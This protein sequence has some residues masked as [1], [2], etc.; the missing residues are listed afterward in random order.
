[1]RLVLTGGVVFLFE[2]W[3]KS[4]KE[5]VDA[6]KAK[7]TRLKQNVDLAI[8]VDIKEEQL[9]AVREQTLNRIKPPEKSSFD[10]ENCCMPDTRTQIVETLVS[11]ALSKD[12]SPRLFLLSGLAGSGKSAVATSVA[13]SLYQHCSLSGSFFFK[14]DIERL[15]IPANLLHAVAYSIALQYKP[16]M[17]VLIDALKS[18]PAIEDAALSIQFDALLRKPLAEVSNLSSTSAVGPLSKQP[19]VTF[20]IDALDECDKPPAIS[21][22]LAELISL[23]PW[24]KVIVTSRPMYECEAEL[25][26]S[27]YMTR[28]NLFAVD[29]SED[30]LKFTQSQFA[31]GRLLHRLQS[32]VTEEEIRAL[33]DKSHGLF[34]WIKT[35]LSYIASLAYDGAKLKEMRSILSSSRAASPENGVDELYL[36]VLRKV[37]GESPGHQDAVK[38][39]V[40]TIYVTSRNR[41][42]PCKGLHAFIPTSDPDILISPGDIEE[43][44]S[45]LAA[46]I[47]VDPVT[48]A[49]RVCHPSFL[50]FISV[51]A[52]SQEFWTDPEM[53]DTMMARRSFAIMNA[54]LTFNICGLESSRQ[55]NN[56]VPGLK[57]RIPEE[58]QYSAV[59]WLDHLS[60]SNGTGNDAKLKVAYDFLYHT[61]LFYWL[62]VMSVVSEINV[63]VQILQKLVVM[64]KVGGYQMIMITIINHFGC[65][66][67]G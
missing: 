19:T 56:E 57:Q 6:L 2:N 23:A 28:L 54:G 7:S 65:G 8:T 24:L 18:N 17:D 46:V 60:R 50:D 33:A 36:R 45:R 41:S 49:L 39:F 10:P 58:L 47:F 59:Y 32:H 21:S 16:Y 37:T 42:L 62:E 44:Q 66:C 12:T 40:G 61:R 4:K 53:L 27:V 11:F 30:I 9:R 13:N 35:V 3:Y 55:R 38:N 52:R 26:G 51:R 14:R 15:R 1:M 5:Q 64:S 31:P 34:I 20:V 63:A 22:Y 43:L 48:D 25:R 29:A 67:I